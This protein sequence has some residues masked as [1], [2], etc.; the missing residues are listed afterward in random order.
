MLWVG[1]AGLPR[2]SRGGL[3]GG[4]RGLPCGL[5]WRFRAGFFAG[6]P[7]CFPAGFRGASVGLSWGFVRASSCFPGPSLGL[8]RPPRAP[9]GLPWGFSS[10]ASFRGPSLG[11]PR[12]LR[13]LLGLPWG[14][15]SGASL[16]PSLGVSLG[17]SLGFAGFLGV[18]GGFPGVCGPAGLPWA[19]L[20]ASLGFL[21][22]GASSGR[23]AVFEYCCDS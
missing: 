13:A 11:L 18:S 9:L 22:L 8:P 21:P 1:L 15:S 14:V 4:F 10:G 23:P 12:P 3:P 20:R 19:S 6:F 17:V 16:G 7:T 2:A 5:P